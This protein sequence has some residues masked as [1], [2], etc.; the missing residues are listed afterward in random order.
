M[1]GD[2]IAGCVYTA[3]SYIVKLY[4]A[5]DDLQWVDVIGAY[6]TYINLP[7][8]LMVLVSVVFDYKTDITMPMFYASRYLD[9]ISTFMLLRK[10]QYD[11]FHLNVFHH[12]TVPLLI[13]AGW[14]DKY[15][16]RFC[17][18]LI[19]CAA[20]AYT[21][22]DSSKDLLDENYLHSF[23][24]VQWTQYIIIVVYTIRTTSKIKRALFVTYTTLFTVLVIQYMLVT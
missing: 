13:R 2:F 4:I 5:P 23:S 7:F 22:N 20:A 18:F 19:G 3:S 21:N 10:Q 11:F 17:V 24:V 15:L 9:Y 6:Y 12:A 8:N 14:D 16:L 1:L